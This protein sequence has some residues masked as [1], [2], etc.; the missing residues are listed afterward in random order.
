MCYVV[1]RKDVN[2]FEPY[3]GDKLYK[4]AYE[5]AIKK[6]CRNNCFIY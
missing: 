1:Q 6:W 5:N 2:K 4:N 3:I